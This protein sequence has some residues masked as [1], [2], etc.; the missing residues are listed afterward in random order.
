MQTDGVIGFAGALDSLGVRANAKALY[1]LLWGRQYVI[2]P[3][4]LSL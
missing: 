1:T 2:K 3:E 4:P